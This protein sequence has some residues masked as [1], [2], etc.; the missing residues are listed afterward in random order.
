MLALLRRIMKYRRCDAFLV[1]SSMCDFHLISSDRVTPSKQVLLTSNIITPSRRCC[2]IGLPSMVSSAMS[3]FDLLKHI[4]SS[5]VL[6]LFSAIFLLVLHC[7]TSSAATWSELSIPEDGKASHIVQSS[8]YFIRSHTLCRS[9]IWCRKPIGPNIV[10]CGTPALTVVY[11]DFTL[12]IFTFCLRWHRKDV[13]HLMTTLRNT[14]D[15]HFVI[16]M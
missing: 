7:P 5:F 11:S 2:W 6:S 3:G 13:S 16:K 14:S 8:T 9:L 10:P 1:I 4:R 15:A 12:P